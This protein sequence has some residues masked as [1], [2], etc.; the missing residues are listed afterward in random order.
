MEDDL[1]ILKNL[2]EM[3]KSRE[4]WIVSVVLMVGMVVFFLMITTFRR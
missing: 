2:N 3:R 4:F 1:F